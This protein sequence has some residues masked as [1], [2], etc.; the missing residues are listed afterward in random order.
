L[1]AKVAEPSHQFYGGAISHHVAL[2]P[3]SFSKKSLT[4]PAIDLLPLKSDTKNLI[5]SVLWQE[6]GYEETIYRRANHRLSQGSGFWTV[7]FTN[8]V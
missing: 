3:I 8:K 5:K 4:G 2:Q 6:N 1:T 7:S